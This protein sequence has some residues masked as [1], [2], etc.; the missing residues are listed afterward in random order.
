MP[1]IVELGFCLAFIGRIR[2][3][4]AKSLQHITCFLLTA[5]L[6]QPPRGFWEE[7]D[8]SEKCKEGDDL[9]SNGKSPADLGRSTL[10]I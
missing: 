3:I 8:D 6:R 2:A 5:D 7:P 4:T 10:N 1:D 9:E